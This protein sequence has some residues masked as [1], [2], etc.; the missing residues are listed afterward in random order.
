MKTRQRKEKKFTTSFKI[1]W[2]VC[3]ESHEN[4]N[5]SVKKQ[6][7]LIIMMVIA[8]SHHW[9]IKQMLIESGQ[10]KFRL[11]DSKYVEIFLNGYGWLWALLFT[12]VYIQLKV[13]DCLFLKWILL[14]TFRHQT[15]IIHHCLY[16]V[17]FIIKQ[18]LKW[19]A[20]WTLAIC[21]EVMP[22]YSTPK[23]GKQWSL[24]QA[25]QIEVIIKVN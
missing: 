13:H 6:R 23:F 9:A 4:T 25:K 16:L 15:L 8:F 14:Y 10:K 18:V 12:S 11:W 2:I 1:R 24:Y 3:Y 17:N 20:N 5:N 21:L 7:T 22:K 19:F